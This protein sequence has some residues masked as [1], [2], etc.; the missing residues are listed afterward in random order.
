MSN[1][2]IITEQVFGGKV[3]E[4]VMMYDRDVAHAKVAANELATLPYNI[5][6]SLTERDSDLD[7]LP[8]EKPNS[9]NIHR[10]M[11]YRIRSQYWFKLIN[12]LNL[13]EKLN[14]DDY[15][16][17]RDSHDSACRL[18]IPDFTVQAVE[19]LLNKYDVKI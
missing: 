13:I 3:Q 14:F 6:R 17:V 8:D 7:I 16:L 11:K 9:L 1:N 4:M 15:K 12:D 18:V 2:N 5:Y 10:V 19:D